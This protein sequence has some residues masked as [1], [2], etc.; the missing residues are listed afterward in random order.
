MADLFQFDRISAKWLFRGK[1]VLPI[2]EVAPVTNLISL[3]KD[4]IPNVNAGVYRYNV[5]VKSGA[6]NILLIH[7]RVGAQE[8]AFRYLPE[9]KGTLTGSLL[10]NLDPG[11][12]LEI[13]Q[14]VL[15]LGHYGQLFRS[16]PP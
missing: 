5:S 15:T 14:A 7:V 11:G 8:M 13:Y 4:V 16:I 6:T 3:K 1:N 10:E 9:G 2:I 12:G